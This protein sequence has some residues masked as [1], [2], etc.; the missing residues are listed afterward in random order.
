MGSITKRGKTFRA[1]VRVGEFKLKPIQKTFPSKTLA[2]R[3]INEKELEIEK[4]IYK[5]DTNY[6][7]LKNLI[8]RYLQEVSC[9]KSPFVRKWEAY[10]LNRFVKD[11]P[12]IHLKINQITPLHIGEFRNKYIQSRKV[13]TWLRFLVILKHMW[14][15]AKTE[16]GYPLDSIF[17]NL[18][19]LKRPLP[20]FRRLTDREMT[21]LTKG[22]HTVELMKNIINLALE[23]GLRRGELL[24]I[25]K[26]H[27]KENTLLIPHRKNGSRDVEIPLSNKAK[28]L[29]TNMELPIPLHYEGLK[30]KW[31]RLKEKYEIEDLT[32]HDLRHEALSRYL[33]MG[34][35]IQDVQ[36]ISGHKDINT[37]LNVYGNLRAGTIAPKL[38]VVDQC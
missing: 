13:S 37:L 25:H 18:Q 17:N 2:K 28:Q 34:I 23:T 20:R 26:E 29:L 12:Q 30:S 3:F 6:P 35:P 7:T 21:L 8:N 1:I 19:K 38:N 10:S 5:T 24:A 14:M 16:W 11:F 32:F 36:V 33:E 15:I 22:N 31:R 27:V 9:R 4:G